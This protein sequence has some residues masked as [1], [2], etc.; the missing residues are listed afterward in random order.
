MAERQGAPAP[1]E[2]RHCEIC[3]KTVSPARATV[4]AARGEPI[5]CTDCAPKDS[6]ERG[7]R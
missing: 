1:W 5:R 7:R 2:H 3:G 6:N 4:C